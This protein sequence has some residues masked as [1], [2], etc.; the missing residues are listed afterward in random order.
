MSS[1]RQYRCHSLDQDIAVAMMALTLPDDVTAEEARLFLALKLFDLHHVTLGRAAEIAGYS[2]AA[3]ME[4]SGKF[5]VAVY[6]H[7][8][9]DLDEELELR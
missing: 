1:A 7:P 5:G 8:P 3:F 9:G 4:V 6:D 2:K